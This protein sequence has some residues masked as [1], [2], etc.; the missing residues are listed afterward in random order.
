M[1]DL[2]KFKRHIGRSVKFKVK[3]EEGIEDEFELKPFSVEQFTE[4][5]LISEELNK[6]PNQVMVKELFSLYVSIIKHSYPN[7][8]EEL[9]E[10]FVI[11]NFVEIVDVLEKLTPAKMSDEQRKKLQE[12]IDKM[13][14]ARAKKQDTSKYSKKES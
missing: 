11:N 1:S 3:N 7:I 14:N 9:A 10:Q 5:L 8:D 12:K 4:F 13:K 2:E 6:N